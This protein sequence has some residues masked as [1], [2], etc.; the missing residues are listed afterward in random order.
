MQLRVLLTAE[1]PLSFRDGV[2]LATSELNRYVPGVAVI[3]ALAE[4]HARAGNARDEFARLFLAEWVLF[5]NAYPTSC[6]T[7]EIA[8]SNHLPVRPI[9]RSARSG[10]RFAGFKHDSAQDGERRDGV[11]DALIPLALFAL[12]DETR[13]DLLEPIRT[14][15]EHGR[16]IDLDR[17]EG[18]YRRGKRS[19]TFSRARIGP[20]LRT[21]TGINY[22][23]GTVQQQI[24][25]STQTLPEGSQ[26]W[27][28]WTIADDPE[29]TLK[30]DLDQL[31]TALVRDQALRLGNN[32]TRGFGLVQAQLVAHAGDTAEELGDRVSTFN[33]ILGEVAQTN[34]VEIP[35][36]LYVPL[37]LTSDTLLQD[38][39]LRARLQLGP[40]DLA[41]YGVPDAEL[42]FHIGSVRRV[43]GWNGLLGLPRADSWAIGMGSVFLFRLPQDFADWEALRRLQEHGVGLR[44]AE[45]YGQLSVADT[46]H[47]ELAGG[48]MG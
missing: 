38:E 36:G 33:Q 2:D 41:A 34:K 39:L 18:F 35:D 32:R 13:A 44:R 14:L 21:R 19:G 5:G 40:A 29:G 37:T 27:G 24:L 1:T 8:E 17:I 20:D 15:E 10:K 23:T 25:Y 48:V 6:V 4:A 46:F 16:Q 3:G 30:A 31:V 42:V 28:V 12:S 22:Q 7:R 45:G 11:T 47:L 43:R 9:P 26:F